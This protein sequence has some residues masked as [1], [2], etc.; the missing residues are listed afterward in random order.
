MSDARFTGDD[1]GPARGDGR[2]GPS[3]PGPVDL[4]LTVPAEV[5]SLPALRAAAAEWVGPL[6]VGETDLGSIQ[7]VLS[8]LAANAIEAS[9]PGD[10]V[11]IELSCEAGSVV[12][13][14]RNP[15]RLAAPVPIPAMAEPLAPR[16][17]GLAIVGSLAERL[18]LRE[19]GGQTVARADLRLTDVRSDV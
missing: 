16:G 10:T 8:E 17:R 7:V 15:S 5:G 2:G 13:V 19:V 11:E 18:S 14:V 1:P 3:R 4:T 6:Q 12:V 9:R